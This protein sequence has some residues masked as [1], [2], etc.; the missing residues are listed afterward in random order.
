MEESKESLKEMVHQKDQELSMKDKELEGLRQE[1]LVMILKQERSKKQE[2][3][4]REQQQQAA[5]LAQLAQLEQ[6]QQES[7]KS[8]KLSITMLL[9]LNEELNEK[10]REL[11]SLDGKLNTANTLL[12]EKTN[13]FQEQLSSTEGEFSSSKQQ[14]KVLEDSK[15]ELDGK[16]NAAN[17]LLDEK[18]N[19]FKEQLSSTKGELSSSKQQVKVLE[20]S[21]KEL[22]GKLNAA[23]TLLNEKT[24]EFKEQLSSAKGELSSSK[25]QVK[26]LKDSKKELDEELKAS[27]T[28]N[29][30]LLTKITKAETREGSLQGEVTTLEEKF[31]TFE[32]EAKTRAGTLQDLQRKA[33]QLLNKASDEV[34]HLQFKCSQAES[35]KKTLTDDLT[36][37]AEKQ[38]EA[39]KNIK[40]VEGARDIL[41]NKLQAA[42]KELR[43][44]KDAKKTLTDDLAS[45]TKKHAEA[46]DNLK[47]VEGA[48]GILDNKLQAAEKALFVAKDGTALDYVIKIDK[49]PNYKESKVQ[50]LTEFARL[51][52]KRYSDKDLLKNKDD[53]K[54]PFPLKKVAEGDVLNQLKYENE[55]IVEIK[56]DPILFRTFN[57]LI[58]N[59]F[60]NS[61]NNEPMSFLLFNGWIGMNVFNTSNLHVCKIYATT[62]ATKR[63]RN[64]DEQKKKSSRRHTQRAGFDMGEKKEERGKGMLWED[65]KIGDQI[66]AQ[67]LGYCQDNWDNV[68]L[69]PSSFEISFE[70]LIPS[71][72]RAVNL[73]F[74]GV[75]PPAHNEQ[76]QN[77]QQ[78]KWW[79][80]NFV[81]SKSNAK[82]FD[83]VLHP[84]GGNGRSTNE[85]TRYFLIESN[86]DGTWQAASIKVN[87]EKADGKT[88]E[89][90]FCRKWF[91]S[92]GMNMHMKSCY[93]Q[94][95][96]AIKK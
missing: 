55:I 43:V 29:A 74:K 73:L 32:T 56:S 54:F 78:H 62:L 13:E 87:K 76:Q 58:R 67:E 25:Q 83:I 86:K 46:N 27:K 33:E 51:L 9:Q 57:D 90:P 7:E 79:L 72:K 80:N 66:L 17:T 70:K 42:E 48:R 40:K 21:K 69:S 36:S 37:F 77:L 39:N 23:N 53:E 95:E 59:I 64:E 45:A 65:L 52:S 4:H 34:Q 75:W 2:R 44:A 71:Q 88:C 8:K 84:H 38:I 35:A 1:K 14:V 41:D 16:L 85:R 15:K 82:A 18:T 19:E 49:N 91:N 11:S 31:M 93:T 24:Y 30:R 61:N 22:D 96:L 50:E 26:V 5:Q 92:Q 81:W 3:L 12:N 68:S 94:I 28:S 60:L 89:C 10:K 63:K 20:D 6:Q 47:K